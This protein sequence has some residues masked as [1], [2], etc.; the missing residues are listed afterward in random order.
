MKIVIVGAG[1]SGI[2]VFTFLKKLLPTPP[3][4]LPPHEILIYE[5]HDASRRAKTAEPACDFSPIGGALGIAPNG[6]KVLLDLDQQIHAAISVQGYPVSFL[7]LK[8][9]YGWLLARFNAMDPTRSMQRT[10]MCSRQAVWDCLRDSIPDDAIKTSSTFPRRLQHRG[11]S[12][13]RCRWGEEHCQTDRHGRRQERQLHSD[14]RVSI[15]NYKRLQE[16]NAF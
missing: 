5:S 3:A 6:M 2:S 9:A 10:I 8:S 4:H 7:Q 16:V 11:R 13:H 12:R 15:T 1:I 14:I